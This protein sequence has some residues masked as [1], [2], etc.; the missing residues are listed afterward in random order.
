MAKFWA[1]CR[2]AMAWGGV[3]VLG[4]RDFARLRPQYDS[5]ITHRLSSGASTKTVLIAVVAFI[6]IANSS[7]F[8]LGAVRLLDCCSCWGGCKGCDMAVS[9]FSLLQVGS[10][11]CFGVSDSSGMSTDT[12][13]SHSSPCR[14]KNVDIQTPRPTC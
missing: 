14:W 4:F 12:T 1:A 8:C 2:I 7:C 5:M 6:L 10:G 3:G 11:G 9:D 13:S